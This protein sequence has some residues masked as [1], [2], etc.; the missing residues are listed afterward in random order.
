MGSV[1]VSKADGAVAMCERGASFD[2]KRASTSASARSDA[3][4][5]CSC[6]CSGAYLRYL[7][8]KVRFATA[9]ALLG[10]SACAPA[11]LRGLRFVIITVLE[12]NMHE[13]VLWEHWCWAEQRF[14]V[15]GEG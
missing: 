4:C 15:G 6:K 10:R 7:W 3:E 9:H 8:Q 5:K 2:A 12:A 14:W 11:G 13:G 1:T